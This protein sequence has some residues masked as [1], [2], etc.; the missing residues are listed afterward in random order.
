RRG[1]A[2][3]RSAPRIGRPSR[4]SPRQQRRRRTAFDVPGGPARRRGTLGSPQ[5]DRDAAPDR[6]GAAEN[7]RSRARDH[8]PR[9]R[10]RPASA[11]AKGKAVYVPG[12]ANK[13][14]ALLARYAPGTVVVPF[15]ARSTLS[16]WRRERS[17]S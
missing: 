9:R 5:R 3:G 8:P 4:G 10:G 14:G 11:A 16:F 15:V 17:V 13:L 6:R 12:M 2:A 1:F 7:A